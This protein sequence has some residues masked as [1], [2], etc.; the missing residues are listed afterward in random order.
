MQFKIGRAARGLTAAAAF[1]GTLA[2][3]GTAFAGECPKDKLAAGFGNPGHGPK[4]V[5]DTVL[6][7]V[8]LGAE[9]IKATGHTFRMRKLVIQP[10]GIVPWHSHAERPAIIYVVSGTIL[11]YASHCTVPIVHKAGEVSKEPS[12]TSHWWKNTGTVPVVLIS[13]DIIKDPNDKNM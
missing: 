2:I 1:A 3:A 11:E 12:G 5:T 7:T 13:A 4:A 8:D 10:G 9:K 6:S